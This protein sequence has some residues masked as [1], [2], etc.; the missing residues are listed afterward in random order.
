MRLLYVLVALLLQTPWVWAGASRSFDGTND[1]IG[2]GSI[3]NLANESNLGCGCW[4][5]NNNLTQDHFILG[6]NVDSTDGGIL[7]LT[8]DVGSSSGR[9][10]TYKIF[11]QEPSASGGSNCFV[12]AASSSALASTWQW[13]AFNFS[14]AGSVRLFIDGTEDANSPGSCTNVS[15]SGGGGDA[16]TMGET[17]SGTLD[18]SGNMAYCQCWSETRGLVTLEQAR[19]LPETFPSAPE[20]TAP[21]FG[22]DSPEIDLSGDG[23]SGT[24]AGAG[25]DVTGPPVMFGLGLP[26]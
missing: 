9:T 16:F 2:W 12:E 5:V 14:A 13:I 4:V 7:F 15:N 10:N 11:I 1:S 19:W 24:V 17:T 18:R 3:A 6:N 20:L 23:N 8:D 25:E 22:S 21:L 26:L